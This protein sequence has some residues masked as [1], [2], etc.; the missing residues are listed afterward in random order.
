MRK[1][2]FYGDSVQ[3]LRY[4]NVEYS[5]P[6]TLNPKIGVAFGRICERFANCAFAFRPGKRYIG[7]CGVDW[8]LDT[9]DTLCLKVALCKVSKVQECIGCVS[10]REPGKPVF[11]FVYFL[12][13]LN[14]RQNAVSFFLLYKFSECS[15]KMKKTAQTVPFNPAYF[16][17]SLFLLLFSTTRLMLAMRFSSLAMNLR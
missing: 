7:W 12:R 6:V 3:K 9:L 16:F 8:M 13:L 17:S 5:E 14:F 11:L 2:T 1:T 10:N 15:D 4:S